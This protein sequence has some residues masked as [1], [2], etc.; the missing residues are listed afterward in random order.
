MTT[1]V[2]GVIVRVHAMLLDVVIAKQGPSSP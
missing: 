1:T 2:S